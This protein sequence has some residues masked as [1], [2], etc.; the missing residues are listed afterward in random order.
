MNGPNSRMGGLA[1]IMWEIGQV[2]RFAV[3]GLVF[4]VPAPVKH[5]PCHSTNPAG[6]IYFLRSI[7]L[8]S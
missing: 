7:G 2:W 8:A 5:F 1:M 6:A 4:G 3:L